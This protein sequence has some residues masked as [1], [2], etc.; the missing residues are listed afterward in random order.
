MANPG[1]KIKLVKIADQYSEV[2][3]GDIGTVISV[4]GTRILV[5]WEVAG[6]VP[7]IEGEDEYTVLTPRETV[8]FKVSFSP[9]NP[10]YDSTFLGNGLIELLQD[11]SV[12]LRGGFSFEVEKTKE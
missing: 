11:W 12:A 10:A 8:R 5:R 9:R 4:D 2:K 3:V 1:D 6:M 7:I